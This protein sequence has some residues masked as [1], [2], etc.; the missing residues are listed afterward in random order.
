MVL[1]DAVSRLRSELGLSVHVAHFDHG[2]RGA[3]SRRDRD[4]VA[5]QAR[6]RGLEVELGSGDVAGQA[7]SGVSVEEA[8]RS[9]RYQFLEETASG[10]GLQLV[11][12]GH[13]RNDQAET[14]LLRLLRG[15]G[16]DG[17]AGMAAV[18]PLGAVQLGRPLLDI[19]RATAAHYATSRQIPFVE[20][21][22]NRD[23]RFA[24][25]R[26]RH[27]LLPVAESIAPGAVATLA[28][29]AELVA[30]ERSWL[31]HEDA[32]RLGD[33]E[34]LH[35]VWPP[36]WSQVRGLDVAG[37]LLL[38]PAQQ[39]RLVRAQ[40]SALQGRPPSRGD[41]QRVLGILAIEGPGR[42][43]PL[44]GDLEARCEGGVLW[45]GH[46]Q[47]TPAPPSEVVPVQGARHPGW[48]VETRW[49]DEMS[50]G[51]VG[52]PAGKQVHLGPWQPG[53]RVRCPGGTRKVSDIL[54]DSKIPRTYRPFAPV[55]RMGDQIVAVWGAGGG[56]PLASA[57][58]D[59]VSRYLL[60]EPL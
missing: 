4:F 49:S 22:S 31:A 19:E 55:L 8:A 6:S 10:L 15:T 16:L 14:L 46:P 5:E 9:A 44:S 58:L 2:L 29:L 1:L 42:G 54:V 35:P 28:R 33:L 39:A 12:T 56:K 47:S 59:G 45:L 32:D 36:L 3:A 48:S 43:C 26:V 40:V 53:D 57:L 50:S 7:H 27:E 20:D 24:R 30:Q 41:V 18:R 38:H 21:A 23:P 37:L 13:T 51:G 60:V 52:I 25:N 34:R 11:V 17:L